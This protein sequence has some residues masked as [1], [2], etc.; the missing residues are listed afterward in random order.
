MQLIDCARAAGVTADTVRHY[1]RIGLLTAEGRTQGGYR[2]FSERS[3]ARV[4]CG[5]LALSINC[6]STSCSASESTSLRVAI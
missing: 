1:L 3:V 5:G 6:S 2:T 4:R